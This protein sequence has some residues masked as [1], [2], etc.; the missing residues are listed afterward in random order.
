MVC[1]SRRVFISPAACFLPN[2]RLAAADAPKTAFMKQAIQ[3]IAVRE[4][5]LGPAAPNTPA[6]A[7]GRHHRPS[8]NLKSVCIP[9][10]FDDFDFYYTDGELLWQP[11]PDQKLKEVRVPDGFC[12]DLTSVPQVFWSM[13]PRT[14]KYAYAAIIH[15]YLYWAQELTRLEADNTLLAAM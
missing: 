7:P 4:R 6:P 14:G 2:V 11:R 5:S 10:P 1:I 15:D 9:V 8:T 13:L 3:Q 12:T